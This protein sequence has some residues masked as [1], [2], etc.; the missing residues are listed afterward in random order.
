M[1]KTLQ[2][3]NEELTFSMSSMIINFNNNAINNNDIPFYKLSTQHY[4][5]YYVAKHYSYI[6]QKQYETIALPLH[7][8]LT[9]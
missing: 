6:F 8:T 5:L 2:I 1:I 7:I 3:N 4:T 9:I